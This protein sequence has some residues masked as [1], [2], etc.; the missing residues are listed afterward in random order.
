MKQG[1]R[2]IWRARRTR[3]VRVLFA[4]L[5]IF[6]LAKP[7]LGT[8][9]SGT[10]FKVVDPV[11]SVGGARVTSTTYTVLSSFGQLAIGT[12]TSNTYRV[13]SGFGF[14]PVATAPVLTATA[15]AAQVSLSWTASTGFLGWTVTSYDVCYGTVSNSYTCT[16]AGNV[17]SNTVTGLTGGTIYYFRVR[18]K[19]TFGVV[20]VRSN[21]ASATPTATTTTTT[22]TTAGNVGVPSAPPIILAG[23]SVAFSG[24]AYPQGAV[25]LLKDAQIA[26]TAV[27]NSDAD[28]NI[29]LTGLSAGKYMFA[30]YGEDSD[31]HRSNLLGFSLNVVSGETVTVSDIFIPPTLF[32]DKSEVKKGDEINI[33]G[34]TAPGANVSIAVASEGSG[35]E[36]LFR[37]VAAK[38]GRYSYALRTEE[39]ALGVYIAKAKATLRNLVSSFG[40]PVEFEVGTK[41]VLAPPV[42]RP[43]KGDFNE[44]GRVNVVDFSVLLYWFGNSSPPLTVDLNR[45]SI[46]DVVDFSIMTYDWTG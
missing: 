8:E 40:A 23:G 1:K 42:K 17:T 45:D 43:L 41:T 26:E 27:A 34:Q 3:V 9:Y 4:L 29:N 28:F 2:S 5:A 33:S 35:K 21:E 30:V 14:F 19:T 22:T 46:V 39:L 24:K 15:G 36:E 6:A 7:A 13:R 16:D 37:A 44:D 38:D 11:I 20:I 32:A 31:G 10:K 25:T 18:A 12:S